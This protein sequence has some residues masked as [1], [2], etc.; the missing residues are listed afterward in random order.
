MCDT[1]VTLSS[2]VDGVVGTGLC[3]LGTVTITSSTLTEGAGSTVG[4]CAGLH[5][6]MESCPEW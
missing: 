5:Q 6:L 4:H 3:A 2:S 1:T